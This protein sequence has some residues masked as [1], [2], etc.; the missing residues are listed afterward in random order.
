[1]PPAARTRST[2]AVTN[3]ND[4]NSADVTTRLTRAKAATLKVDELA[5]PAKAALQ[6]KKAAVNANP[7][8]KRAA[9]GD[10]SNVTKGELAE[11]KK[12]AGKTGLVS[13][14]AHPTGIQ[15]KTAGRT[16]LSAKSTSSKAA[17]EKKSGAGAVSGSKRTRT[18]ASAAVKVES[19]VEAEPPR[20]NPKVEPVVQKPAVQKPAVQKSV[21]QKPAVQKQVVQKPAV[22]KPVVEKPVVEK[23]TKKAVVEEP[24]PAPVVNEPVEHVYPRGV[25]NLDEED[26]DDPLMVA[27]YANDIFEYLRDLEC[28]S[29]PNPQYMS[30]QDDLE[31]KTRGILIDWLVEV[32]TRFHLLPETLFL[33]VNIIDRF[34][35]EKVVQ[36]DRLQLVGIT[37]MFIASKYE[38]VLSP[39][40]A[41]FRHVADDGFSEAEILSAERFVLQTLNYDLSYPNPMNFLRRISKADNYDIQSRTIGK[42]LMEISLLDHRF[43]AYRPSHIAAAAMYLARLILDRGPWDETIAYYAGYTEEE[44]AP[45]FLLMVDY[46]A[47]P[48]V[49]EAFFK[50][51]ASKKF[52]KASILT[53]QWAKKNAAA[54]DIVDTDL[55]LDDISRC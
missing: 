6:S 34:L 1:M 7:T 41:N 26:F 9:L 5:M 29:V 38:E 15:K 21:V 40:I 17:V 46:L 52:L 25:K 48:V 44:I 35:S 20:K 47:R 54:Y 50:K 42:Y 3:E 45:V 37:A 28:N 36:L 33:A 2:R 49:H 13:K 24:A 14:A 43:M 8:R 4:E 22:E 51:Y 18:A 31:W 23:K 53:R 16:A 27:E 32:H 10:L 55:S 12:A 11:G 19:T 39:H 30:H